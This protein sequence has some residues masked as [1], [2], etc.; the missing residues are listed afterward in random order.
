VH[1]K[2]EKL[3]LRDYAEP[4]C[5]TLPM[6]MKPDLLSFLYAAAIKEVDEGIGRVMFCFS[7][8]RSYVTAN[9]GVTQ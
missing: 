3:V 8:C 4:A 5:A 6:K 7:S 9:F 2:H 1:G